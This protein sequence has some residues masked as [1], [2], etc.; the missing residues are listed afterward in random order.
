[1]Q[2]GDWEFTPPDPAQWVWTDDYCNI[3]GAVLRQLRE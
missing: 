2:S 3:L 1:V